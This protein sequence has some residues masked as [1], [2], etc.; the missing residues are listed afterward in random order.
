MGQIDANKAEPQ[1][2]VASVG[3][4]SRDAVA[5]TIVGRSMAPR[6]CDGD[7]VTIGPGDDPEPGQLVLA[8]AAGKFVFRRYLPK[9]ASSHVGARLVALNDSFPE[10]VM[11]KGDAILGIMGEHI[12][13]RHE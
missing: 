10:I 4:H 13:S 7:I 2:Y 1:K 3:K 11:T 8:S 9:S 6:F 12:S 5:F